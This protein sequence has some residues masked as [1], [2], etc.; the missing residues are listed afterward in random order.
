[1]LLTNFRI[2]ITSIDLTSSQRV[3]PRSHLFVRVL[4]VCFC[5]YNTGVGGCYPYSS[6]AHWFR[7]TNIKMFRKLESSAKVRAQ[8]LS[9]YMFTLWTTCI[10][11]VWFLVN[12]A[13]FCT[14]LWI[15]WDFLDFH[16]IC[17][18]LSR[19]MFVLL[20]T[21]LSLFHSY[22][23]CILTSYLSM[24][25][26]CSF[27]QHTDSSPWIKHWV[28]IKQVYNEHVDCTVPCKRIGLIRSDLSNL[29]LS[30]L[31]A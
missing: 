3:C 22:T 17:G 13:L 10:H 23:L 4:H 12:F 2:Y 11:L 21:L 20:V 29:L 6:K 16:E 30:E 27:Q 25:P 5:P 7:T 8:L 31:F 28:F 1:M 24:A 26:I 15:S 9:I 14:F 19:L 18:S